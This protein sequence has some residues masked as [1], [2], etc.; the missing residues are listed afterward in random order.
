MLQQCGM[1]IGQLRFSFYFNPLKVHQHFKSN[2][3]DQKRR[4][5][6]YAHTLLVARLVKNLNALKLCIFYLQLTVYYLTVIYH[7]LRTAHSQS[8]VVQ[9]NVSFVFL[10]FIPLHAAQKVS[11]NSPAALGKCVRVQP[12]D[13]LGDRPRQRYP[14]LIHTIWYKRH[15]C[16]WL[17]LCTYLSNVRKPVCL[18]Y[19]RVPTIIIKIF[20]FHQ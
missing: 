3:I 6:M 4:Y 2:R 18:R 8:A 5:S 20:I 19:E 15:L 10:I 17:R 12:H 11:I 7:Q 14:S 13:V 16:C 9:Q 1:D